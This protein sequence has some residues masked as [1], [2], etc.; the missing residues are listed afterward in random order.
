VLV[1]KPTGEV[2]QVAEVFEAPP[3]QSIQKASALPKTASSLPLVL[4]IGVLSLALSFGISI[5][6]LCAR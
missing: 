3:V 4:L 5:P 6:K 1:F 2:V